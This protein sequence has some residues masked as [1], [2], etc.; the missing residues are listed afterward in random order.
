M[1]CME[2]IYIKKKSYTT[3]NSVSYLL[4]SKWVTRGIPEF[5][6]RKTVN[7]LAVREV[8]RITT[9]FLKTIRDFIDITFGCNETGDKL[10]AWNRAA[11]LIRKQAIKGDY[12]ELQINF[13]NL[14]LS[15]GSL[16]QVKDLQLEKQEDHLVY[17]WNPESTDPGMSW[18]DKIM[19][20][21]YS[22]EFN[23]AEFML[24]GANRKTGLQIFKPLKFKAPRI[25]ET[26]I[27]FISANH[28]VVMD[29]IYT[30]RLIW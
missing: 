16:E 4:N 3:G 25:M 8:T 27:T 11:S 7:Q 13:E 9:A 20:L 28:K 18:N 1:I 15:K 23:K 14:S 12:P 29:S 19:I 10:N 30:G 2:N 24:N 6:D 22:P 26:Y 5:K 17:S 21:A